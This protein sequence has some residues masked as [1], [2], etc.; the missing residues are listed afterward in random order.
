MRYTKILVKVLGIAVLCLGLTGFLAPMGH[1]AEQLY[2]VTFDNEL[3]RINTTTG[4]GALVGNFSSN[5]AAF[6]LGTRNNKLYTYDQIADLVREL[7]PVNAQTVNSINIGTILVGEGGLTFR[8]DGIGFL[9]ST[10][11]DS[12]L[13]YSFDLTVPSSQNI[14]NVNHGIN[15]DYS[16]IML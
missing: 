8:A 4:A 13:L 16:S 14:G 7:N 2:G 12:S 6:G 1:T 10:S 9:C 3:I 5:M 15:L 11:G